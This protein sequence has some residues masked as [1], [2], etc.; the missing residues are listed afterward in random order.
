MSTRDDI[1]TLLDGLTLDVAGESVTLAA[2]P[3]LPETIQPWTAWPVWS[4]AVWI[5]AC[6]ADESW[7]VLVV[8]PASGSEASADALDAAL[9][10]VREQLQKLG[11]VPRA[12]PIALA[13]GDQSQTMP[14]L[15]YT[16]NT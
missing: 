4:G 8:L 13:V 11:A 7:R 2:F 6:V 9:W 3:Q 5:S 15:A 16:L 1:A 10:P 14:A 12:D